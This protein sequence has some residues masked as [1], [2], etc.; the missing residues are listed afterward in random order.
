MAEMDRQEKDLII[1]GLL[2][3]GRRGEE[4][5]RGRKRKRQRFTYTVQGE[6]VSVVAFRKIY[7]IGEKAKK[8]LL[9][10]LEKNAAFLRIHGNSGRKPHNALSFSVVEFV[11]KFIKNHA[12]FCGL[13]HPA[14][15]RGHDDTPPAYLPTTQKFKTVHH[16]YIQLRQT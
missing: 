11:V 7:G 15:L 10:L 9:K 12:T 6:N 13:P 1:L 16:T 14:P 3:Y 2:E 4:M 8:N 5:T